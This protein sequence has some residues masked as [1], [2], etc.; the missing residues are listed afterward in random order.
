MFLASRASD[1]QAVAVQPDSQPAGGGRQ[2]QTVVDHSTSS[3]LPEPASLAPDPSAAGP[4]AA[5]LVVLVVSVVAGA[6]D[7]AVPARSTSVVLVVLVVVP[8][9][10]PV[11]SPAGAFGAFCPVVA[12]SVVFVVPLPVLSGGSGC[13]SADR[14]YDKNDL[15]DRI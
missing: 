14:G 6:S 13:S 1:R 5:D 12:V 4:G 9:A 3:W 10:A 8:A 7:L 11:S 15:Y 2:D